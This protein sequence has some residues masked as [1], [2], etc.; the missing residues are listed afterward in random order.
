MTQQNPLSS[1]LDNNINPNINSNKF[2][3]SQQLHL[4][5]QSN[6]ISITTI[7]EIPN[8]NNNNSNSN[9]IPPPTAQS[10]ISKYNNPV[11]KLEKF[12]QNGE[13]A[14]LLHNSNNNSDFSIR[15]FQKRLERK[16]SNSKIQFTG[17]TGMGSFGNNINNNNNNPPLKI[18]PF[19]IYRSN[20]YNSM[21]SNNYSSNYQTQN[22][23][24]I[25]VLPTIARK[26]T[27]DHIE[28]DNHNQHF[29][30]VPPN[31]SNARQTNIISNSNYRPGS[32]FENIRSGDQRKIN[33]KNIQLLQ[34]ISGGTLPPIAKNSSILS[35]GLI[36]ILQEN[37][38]NNDGNHLTNISEQ[39]RKFASS[40]KHSTTN[41]TRK[42]TTLG[43]G[44]TGSRPGTMHASQRRF[45]KNPLDGIE[46]KKIK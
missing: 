41:Y 4:G 29:V 45:A 1:S 21:N 44:K 27:E 31:I 8:I 13:H 15:G 9:P 39:R 3:K 30:P 6:K 23:Q 33:Y 40:A 12:Y 10:G 43:L 42:S 28:I 18:S 22:Y 2:R 37:P 26:T 14:A 11:D 38:N 17:L 35:S 5:Q 32:S 16:N 25:E 20:T 7:P 24:T 36:G 46:G 19:D 34:N